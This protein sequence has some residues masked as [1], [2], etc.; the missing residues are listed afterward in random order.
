[1]FEYNIDQF[2]HTFLLLYLFTVFFLDHL[3]LHLLLYF[4][5]DLTKTFSREV[6]KV[7]ILGLVDVKVDEEMMLSLCTGLSKDVGFSALSVVV[8]LSIVAL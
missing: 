5:F 8:W 7:E 2:P 3:P 4:I 6:P 1:M